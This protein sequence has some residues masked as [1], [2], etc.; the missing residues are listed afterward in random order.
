M[1]GIQR[2]QMSGNDQV[3]DSGIEKTRDLEGR[4]RQVTQAFTAK[5]GQ[6]PAWL[7]TAPGRVNLIGEH[8]DYNDGFV[9]PMAIDRRVIM[10]GGLSGSADFR[11]YR[12]WIFLMSLPKYQT[13]GSGNYYGF[14]VLL[15]IGSTWV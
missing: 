10:A 2:G 8:T 6:Q 3:T 14:F 1:D 9:M 5:F 11:V 7:V 4:V 15:S 12:M 13:R